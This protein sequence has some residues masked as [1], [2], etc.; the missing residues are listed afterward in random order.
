[1]TT[2]S[3]PARAGEPLAPLLATAAQRVTLAAASRMRTGCLTV[4]LPDGSRRTFGDPTSD[5]R[6]EMHIHDLAALERLLVGGEV[7]GGEAYVDGLWSSPDLVALISLAVANRQALALSKGWWRL[8][9]RVVRTVSH[10]RN[11]NTRPGSRRNIA[12]HYDLGNDFYSLWLDETMT[13]SSAVFATPEQ[14]LADA[15]RN[16]Y[17]LM[18]ARAGLAAGQHVLEIGTGWGGFALYAAGELG[19]RVTTVTVSKAQHELAGR[20]VREAG[21]EDRVRVELRDYRDIE[22]TY[23]AIVS[24]EMLEAVGAEYLGTFFRA[25]DRALRT[26]GRMSVQVI[27][28]PDDAYESQLRGANWIQ[29]YIFPGG[30]LPSLAA[31]ER[32]LAGTQLLV[33]GVTDIRSSYALTLRA[34]R[35]RF[36]ERLAEVRAMGFDDRFIRMWDYYLS[37]SEAGFRTGMTQDLQIAFEKR[38]GVA[39]GPVRTA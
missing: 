38:R 29:R 34:W 39:E 4:V 33:T 7:G 14:S 36:F 18:A 19:C 17:R 12:A 3:W 11:R 16:K 5:L 9:A 2:R 27:T 32:S 20:R 28:F 25:C 23:D 21:L 37:I 35:T 1:M 10:R 22:G 6:G 24:I 26:G 31:I 15:Q 8:P 13:Y 30:V